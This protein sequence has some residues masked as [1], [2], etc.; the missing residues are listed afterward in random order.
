MSLI[1]GLGRSPGGGRDN[2]LQY[3][4]LGNPIDKGTCKAAVHGVTKEFSTTEQLSINNNKTKKS[5]W[6]LPAIGRLGWSLN[7]RFQILC[8]EE[9]AHLFA[10]VFPSFSFA[11]DKVRQHLDDI[12]LFQSCYLFHLEICGWNFLLSV[13]LLIKRCAKKKNRSESQNKQDSVGNKP[14]YAMRI[15]KGQQRQKGFPGQV[16]VREKAA[17]PPLWK[18]LLWAIEGCPDRESLHFIA[19]GHVEEI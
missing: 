8:W 5:I 11:F 13:T 12:C 10:S 19:A 7:K 2:P 17:N 16:Q 4:C 6:P 9:P 3:S 14:E 1:P 18:T 15:L